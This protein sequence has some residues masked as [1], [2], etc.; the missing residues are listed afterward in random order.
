MQ[1]QQQL[2]VISPLTQQQRRAMVYRWH[3]TFIKSVDEEIMR[4]LWEAPQ[5]AN[6][7]F[8]SLSLRQVMKC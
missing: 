2:V 7:L 8:L 1:E 4:A 6:P 5:C 3:E